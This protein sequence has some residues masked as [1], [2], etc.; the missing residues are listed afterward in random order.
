MLVDSHCHLDHWRED[1]IAAVVARAR[2]A[3]VIALVTIGTRLAQAST[4]K[5]IAETHPEVWCTVGIHPHQAAEAPVPSVE[6]LLA[7]AD[8]PRV[9]G[10]GEA[11]LDYHYDR[12]P[13]DV[14][15][16]VFRVQ[17]RAAQASGLPL[18]VHA[19]DADA[20]IAAILREEH[21]RGGPFRFVLHCF[22][23]GRALAETGVA[24]GG[25]VSFSGILTFKR[26]ED[27]RALARELPA[28]RL[29][30]ETDAPFLAPEP[31][32]G[33]RCEPAMVARTAACLAAVRGVS[34]AELAATT[35]ANALRLFGRM[36][37]PTERQR[38]V[39]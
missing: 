35:T 8:H 16:S 34:V 27:L 31:H 36:V 3:G 4:I 28:D 1:E 38:V 37:L 39:A 2:E 15:A 9:V 11:G 13:R 17:I 18:V 22:S 6:E 14:A 29:L 26:S 24:L 25:M 32:R 7:L 30:V 19:R 5:R 23:S 33:R 12:A 21:D 20:D 10:I